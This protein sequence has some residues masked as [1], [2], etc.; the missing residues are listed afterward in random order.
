MGDTIPLLRTHVSL[1]GGHNLLRRQQLMKRANFYLRKSPEESR[2]TLE[3]LR[4]KCHLE[5]GRLPMT[6]RKLQRVGSQV[7][8]TDGFWYR[9]HQNLKHLF[10]RAGSATL[11]VTVSFADM[12]DAHLHR[13]LQTTSSSYSGRRKK[14]LGNPHLCAKY[15]HM[16]VK[17]WMKF[18][19]EQV[20]VFLVD[21]F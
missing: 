21:F 13:L 12:H 14:T 9:N 8:G 2:M 3:Q 19:F 15:F 4:T 18:L 20:C 16:K 10:L 1:F 6:I 11:F 17:K 7:P 5:K